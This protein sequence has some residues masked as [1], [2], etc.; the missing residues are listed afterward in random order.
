M[1]LSGVT[2]IVWMSFAIQN[3][4]PAVYSLGEATSRVLK[5]ALEAKR[6]GVVPG[7][8]TEIPEI[9]KIL[10]SLKRGNLGI[11]AA[12][13]SH[14][15]T[16][17]ATHVAANL[18]KLGIGVSFFTLEM[19]ADELGQR[20]LAHETGVA[21]KCITSG[22]LS[23]YEIELITD[24]DARIQAWPLKIEA[25]S[26]LTV[27][28]ME[29]LV[30]QHIRKHKSQLVIVDYIGLMSGKGKDLYNQLCDITRNLKIAAGALGV[31]I[32]ALS[33]LNRANERRAADIKKISDRYLRRRPV[34]SDLRDSGSIEQDADIVIFL[35]REE[36]YLRREEP[37]FGDE[38]SADWA[39][40]LIPHEGKI[41][42]V[43]AKQRQD[44]I[45]VVTMDYDARRFRFGRA[46]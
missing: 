40:A 24:A 44:E 2:K 43:I 21:I 1:R 10:A 30:R 8:R 12:A 11:I 9:D 15:K 16:A 31:P 36:I 37:P 7:V 3:P 46:A 14:G 26:R 27:P 25:L 39:K 13:T 4:R 33:Q 17:L 20:F 19:T 32:L 35:H 6:S 5:D 29:R 41:D 38:T 18:A 34:L 42:V 45:G 23:Q 22:N 28:H